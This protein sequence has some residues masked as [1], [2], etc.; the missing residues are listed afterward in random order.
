MTVSKEKKG[1]LILRRSSVGAVGNCR[2]ELE[3]RL[4]RKKKTKEGRDGEEGSNET[5]VDAPSRTE[6]E[7]RWNPE[8]GKQGGSV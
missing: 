4:G 7:T 1:F 8:V 6:G 5:A 2:R 3:L